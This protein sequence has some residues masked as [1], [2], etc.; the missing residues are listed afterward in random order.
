M[1]N[2]QILRCLITLTVCLTCFCTPA[3]AGLLNEPIDVSADFSEPRNTFFVAKKLTEFDPQTGEGKITWQRSRLANHFSFNI[4][5]SRF[6]DAPPNEFPS[7]EYEANP[8]L[9]FSIQFVS[10]RVVRIRMQ[11]SAMTRPSAKSLMLVKEPATDHS[12]QVNPIKGGFEYTSASGKLTV[13]QDPWRLEFRDLTG[14]LL[15]STRSQAGGMPF[16]FVRRSEDYSRSIAPVFSLASG[17][18]IFGCGESFTSFDKRGQKIVLWTSDALGAEKPLMYKPIPFFMSNRG[19]GMFMHTSSPITCDIGATSVSNNTLMIGDDELDLFVFLGS[20]KDILADYT[21]LTGRASMPPLWSFGL[22]MSRITYNSEKQV[23]DVAAKLRENRIPCDVIHLDTGWFTTD[24][25]CD[26]KFD[27]T[28]FPDP[29]K[30]IT[31]LKDQ[32]FHIS[33]WQLP[34]FVPKNPLFPEIVDK[35]LAVKDAKGNLPTEDAILDFSNPDAV[36]WY[37]DHLAELLKMG[38]GAIK[39]DFGEA[40]PASGLYASGRTGFYEHNLYPLR[41]QQAV[42]EIT[43]RTT[44]ENIIWAR[45]GWAGSQRYPLHWSGDADNTDA[46]MG[47]TLRA[48]LSLGVCGFSFWSHD[49]GGFSRRPPAELYR[50]WMPFGMLTSHS[51]CHGAPPREPWE[52]GQEFMD[53]FRRADELKYRLM[54]YV[55]AQAKDCTE[56]GLPMTRALFVEFPDDP[57]SWCVDDEYLL[58]SSILVA[59]LFEANMTSRNVYLPP[60]NWIDYQTKKTYS[61]GWQHIDAGEIP[62]VMLIRD[63]TIL[64]RLDL[65]QT[66]SQMDWSKIELAVFATDNKPASGWVCLPSDQKLQKIDANFRDGKYELASDP[67]NGNVATT[68]VRD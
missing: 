38:V 67:F 39:T 21:D 63:G 53:D 3:R 16:C 60:G 57:G 9:P 52:Y 34:Y 26:Y 5:Q 28:R 50:R 32:G 31:D 37:Q 48:G 43:K 66:T 15:T 56:H 24:W 54:P 2:A 59:P 65:A 45:A 18:K 6:D 61:S 17:E 42:A 36:K 40:G 25:R 55:Y 23:R 62:I 51:R 4:M 1:K 44:G 12:W 11:T 27:P 58:G 30:M 41:Y 10:P 68:I 7:N 8:S 13:L 22:W 64:P 19:Y 33:L 14:R 49:I 20:P 46:A 47:A 35:N 29:A